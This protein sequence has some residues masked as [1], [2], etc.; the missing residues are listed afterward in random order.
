MK[1]VKNA[2]LDKSLA[3]QSRAIP[4]F[5]LAQLCRNRYG[6][7]ESYR[8]ALHHTPDAGRRR[9]IQEKITGVIHW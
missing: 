2:R 4:A 1:L 9:F 3:K 7:P 5:Q 8:S 6:G